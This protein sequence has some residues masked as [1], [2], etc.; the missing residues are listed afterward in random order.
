MTA[1]WTEA[2]H[3]HDRVVRGELAT[4]PETAVSAFARFINSLPWRGPHLDW[5]S[6]GGDRLSLVD[7]PDIVAW[8]A[9]RRIGRHPYVM[10]IRSPQE[11]GLIGT[12]EGILTSIDELGWKAPGPI[13][14]CGCASGDPTSAVHEDFAEYDGVEHLIAA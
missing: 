3:I 11:L 2:E 1:P 14:L 9:S 10:A 8:T 6:I 12:A 5:Q 13:Y 7:R 4:V